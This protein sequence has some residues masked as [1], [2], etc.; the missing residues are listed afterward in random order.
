[1]SISVTARFQKKDD[2]RNNIFMCSE[3]KEPKSYAWCSKAYPKLK[4]K[5]DTF[6]PLYLNE[7]H[8]YARLQVRNSYDTFEQDCQ[9]QLNLQIRKVKHKGKLYCNLTIN[10]W[11]LLKKSDRGEI[12]ELDI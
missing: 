3:A 1:M 11:K 10:S 9:Y 12:I 5:F 6:L 4:E 8:E 2:Y 7:D